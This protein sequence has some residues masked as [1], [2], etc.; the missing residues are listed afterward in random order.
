MLSYELGDY[1]Q[2]VMFFSQI[3]DQK[4][5]LDGD[6]YLVLSYLALKQEQKA[7]ISWQRLIGYTELQKSDFYTFFQEAF[8]KP[9]RQ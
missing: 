9:Y 1:S 4:L 8:W 6:R 7:L 5:T 3:T 2:A